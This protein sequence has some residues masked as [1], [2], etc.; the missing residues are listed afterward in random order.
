[1]AQR[2]SLA[3]GLSRLVSQAADLIAPKDA[4]T[5]GEFARRYTA[6]K[7]KTSLRHN[8][9]D[10]FQRQQTKHLIPAFGHLP[11][12]QI[13]NEAWLDW[14]EAT[15]KIGRVNRFFN[16]RKDLIETLLAAKEQGLLQKVPK[17]ENPDEPKDVG[18]VL[19]D[20]EVIAFLWH[21]RRPFRLMFYA[22]WKTGVRPREVFKWEWEMVNF[23]FGLPDNSGKR[24]ML[25][26][27]VDIPA[28]ITKV[29]KAR[30]IPINTDLSKMLFIKKRVNKG[31]KFVFPKRGDPSRPQ[32]SYAS[33]WKTA[34]DRAG[35]TN[36]MP[37]DFRRTFITRCAKEGK[38][39][40][41]VAKALGTSPAMISKHY[42]KMDA[43]ALESVVS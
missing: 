10:S 42:V 37:Y 41:F 27:W 35:I 33:S 20:K 7:M 12:D 18:R 5:Y 2:R 23:V 43:K 21:S 40:D 39:M 36:A 24:T 1:M 11:I 28:R 30:S 16:P 4:I 29:D 3:K 25:P 34:C 22:L 13:T 32:L 26:A 6:T 17:F 8:T 19:E 38:S 15:R 14:V 31:A 9:K